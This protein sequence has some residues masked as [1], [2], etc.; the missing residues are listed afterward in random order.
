M[1][2]SPARS[3]IDIDLG[4]LIQWNRLR[5]DVSVDRDDQHEVQTRD[6]PHVGFPSRNAEMA[7]FK[8]SNNES[9]HPSFCHTPVTVNGTLGGI[10]VMSERWR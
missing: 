9:G 10:G 1:G 6:V 8:H 4:S 3:V 7:G 5:I 2:T